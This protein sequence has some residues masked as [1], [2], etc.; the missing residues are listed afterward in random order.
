MRSK[1]DVL[2]RSADPKMV[3]TDAKR[4]L[5]HVMDVTSGRKFVTLQ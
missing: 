4:V 2:Q 5:A 1:A 3:W